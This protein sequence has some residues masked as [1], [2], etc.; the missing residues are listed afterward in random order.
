MLKIKSL[1][2]AVDSQPILHNIDLQVNPGEVHAIMGPNGSGKSTLVK[3]LAGHEDYQIISGSVEFM[4]QDL[5]E[6]SVTERARAGL[7]LGFQYPLEI[8]GVSTMAFLKAAYDAISESRNKDAMDS[9]EFLKYVR[10]AA[11]KLGLAPDLLKRAVNEGFSGG[12]KKS[13]EILQMLV[14]QPELAM[15]D[16]IDSGLDIDALARVAKGINTYRSATKSQLLVTHYPRIL[17]MIK[18]DFVH[19][20][21]QGRLIRSGDMELANQ[22]EDKGYQWL[23]EA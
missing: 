17:N 4:G 6:L 10:L 5:L 8:P 11:D 13:S 2:V 23:L 9:A 21:A 14:L 16:E 1:N 19:V 12:E 18:P 20:L 22:L 3:A 7:F 15:L